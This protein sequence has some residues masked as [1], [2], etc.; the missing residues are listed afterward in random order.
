MLLAGV[1]SNAYF[2]IAVGSSAFF[3]LQSI[4]TFIGIGDNFEIDAD[5]DAEVDVDVDIADGISMT[6]HLFTIRGIISFFMVFGWTG[7][8]LTNAGEIGGVG[9]FFI[10]LTTGTI[11]LFLIAMVYYL[12][13]KLSQEGNVDLKQAIG[14]QGSVYIPIPKRNEGIGKVQIVLSESLKTLDAMAKDNAISTGSQVRVVGI[15][16]EML[17]VEEIKNREEK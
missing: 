6:M 4:F 17:E 16:N 3:I 15:I 12:F 2:Y 5:F 14:K 1:L 11:M 13:E 9:I 10:S 7:F 8:I